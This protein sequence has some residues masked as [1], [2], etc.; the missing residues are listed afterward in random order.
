M[1]KFGLLPISEIF[2]SLLTDKT[3]SAIHLSSSHVARKALC[4]CGK[5][6]AQGDIRGFLLHPN[7]ILSKEKIVSKLIIWSLF[8]PLPPNLE[9]LEENQGGPFVLAISNA[10]TW[11]FDQSLRSEFS[12]LRAQDMAYL[13]IQVWSCCTFPPSNWALWFLKERK[14]NSCI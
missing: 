14:K 3:H 7:L 12:Q 9:I 6:T 4:L 8:P 11:P 13:K 5:L 1:A 2:R 10:T